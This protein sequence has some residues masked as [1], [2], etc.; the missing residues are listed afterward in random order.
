VKGVKG[1]LD[2]GG[3]VD[4]EE[5]EAH[6]LRLELSAKLPKPSKDECQICLK[7]FGM[8]KRPL[9]CF[10][11]DRTV[12]DACSDKFYSKIV[13]GWEKSNIV[14]FSC[15][16]T[17]KTKWFEEYNRK[18]ALD[19]SFKV[20]K[21]HESGDFISLLPELKKDPS[22]GKIGGDL[23]LQ[24]NI[25]VGKPKLEYKMSRRTLDISVRRTKEEKALAKLKWKKNIIDGKGK[26]SVCASMF[27]PTKR[28]HECKMCGIP[29]CSSCICNT[30]LIVVL[31]WSKSQKICIKCFPSIREQV[32]LKIKEKPELKIHAEKELEV[33]KEWQALPA[34]QR[35]PRRKNGSGSDSSD[36]SSS[37]NS[38][39][40]DKK[41]GSKFGFGFGGK[42]DIKGGLKFGGEAHVKKQHRSK[43][44]KIE[45]KNTAIEGGK[46]CLGCQSKFSLT[47][48]PHQCA[49]C[50]GLFCSSCSTMSFTS[51][52]LGWKKPKRLCEKCVVN[53]KVKIEAQASFADK[54][55]VEKEIQELSRWLSLSPNL[56][57]PKRKDGRDGS[58]TSGSSSAESSSDDEKAKK[59]P[60]DCK[61]CH[62]DFG[63]FKKSFLC[64]H[65]L[66]YVCEDCSDKLHSKLILGWVKPNIVCLS[67]L[68]AVKLKW[69]EEHTRKL[70]LNSTLTFTKDDESLDFS[71]MLSITGNVPDVKVKAKPLE[72]K[73]KLKMEWR[74]KI[75]NSGASCAACKTKFS[76]TRR[77]HE[78]KECSTTICSACSK[79]SFISAVLGW[80]HAHRLCVKCLP[81]MRTK[82]EA[83]ISYNPSLKA[84]GDRELA[85]IDGWLALAPTLRIP[86]RKDGREGSESSDSSSSNDE[87]SLKGKIDVDL[88]LKA[89][90]DLPTVKGKL[91]VPEGSGKG[92]LEVRTGALGHK[93][94]RVSVR[95]DSIIRLG[96]ICSICSVKFSFFKRPHQCKECKLH[97]CSGCSSGGIVSIVLGWGG[98]PRRVC[99]K[100]VAEVKKKLEKRATMMPELK[101]QAEKEAKELDFRISLKIDKKNR[102]TEDSSSSS[103]SDGGLALGVKG[104]KPVIEYKPIS[105]T[106]KIC[107]KN[108]GPTVAAAQCTN[109]SGEVCLSCTSALHSKFLGWATPKVVCEECLPQI[110][111]RWLIEKE[112]QININPGCK[113]DETT[114]A[115]FFTLFDTPKGGISGGVRGTLSAGSSGVAKPTVGGVKGGIGVSGNVNVGVSGNVGL[116]GG[117]GKKIEKG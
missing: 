111:A 54:A 32:Q 64:F 19:A 92:K 98:K 1:G 71:N 12:C 25:E 11:C 31:G 10:E 28:P 66:T 4:A 115:P 78:C 84:K 41:G 60:P 80:T 58:D 38:D 9:S 3:K 51:I 46:V 85:D 48:R 53:L 72:G 16:P 81:K 22:R 113:F 15:L 5:D 90:V 20:A 40:E 117:G 13:L 47:K 110:K 27:S 49:E 18:L 103:D 65:C 33:F 101:L 30:S 23:S 79:G 45:W 114:E 24:A 105:L 102:N 94:K 52:L 8:F 107:K 61:I 56:R 44:M 108:F 93:Q 67:C 74:T 99:A 59:L 82:I 73:L 29:A 91:D 37:S 77:P 70:K 76:N 42:L 17:I 116:S 104:K 97:V 89:K 55:Q 14:C 21:E 88:S 43:D 7:V 2:L 6:K 69:K 109:C 63:M 87:S 36:S 62:K 100:C 68:T 75:L 35:I 86:K 83:K 34:L 50:N 39:S 106:C 96:A 57:L 95:Q 26:C 112:K